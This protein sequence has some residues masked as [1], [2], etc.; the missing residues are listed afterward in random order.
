VT[1][2][3]PGMIKDMPTRLR[4]LDD[5]LVNGI[6]VGLRGLA[7]TSSGMERDRSFGFT[8]RITIVPVS[9]GKGRI[10]GFAEALSDIASSIG[11]RSEVSSSSDVAGLMEAYRN[12]SDIVMMAD[13]DAFIAFDT[14][15]RY[16]ADNA[17]STANAYVTALDIAVGGL[18]GKTVLVVGAGCV[19]K[20]AIDILL[21]RGASV[22]VVDKD[23]E[24][25]KWASRKKGLESYLLVEEGVPRANIILNASPAQI[26]SDLLNEGTYLSNPGV[27][28]TPDRT[29][30]KQCKVIV[31]DPLAIGA[32]AMIANVLA[33]RERA[34]RTPGRKRSAHYEPKLIEEV[35]K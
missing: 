33:G 3:T 35:G 18:T 15:R 1:R 6:G 4:L 8:P 32:A 23:P 10:E 27:P 7:W 34:C 16:V 30:V 22:A 20:H 28:F 5:Q 19:G 12:R 29:C 2:L 25:Y 13:D 11:L 24:R 21:S 9:S 26:P 31:H 17:Y 14:T